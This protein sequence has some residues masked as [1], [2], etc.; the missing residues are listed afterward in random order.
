MF[1][2]RLS[3]S[4]LKGKRAA[5]RRRIGR[6]RQIAAQKE[7]SEGQRKNR[8]DAEAAAQTEQRLQ[9]AVSTLQQQL[10]GERKEFSKEKLQ[11]RG[12]MRLS[13]SKRNDVHQSTAG[14]ADEVL[15]LRKE[16]V[17]AKAAAGAREERLQSELQRA[18]S[19]SETRRRV[20]ADSAER[21]V[22]EL[23]EHTRAQEQ[24]I[25]A[26]Q[27]ECGRA[28][29]RLSLKERQLSDAGDMLDAWRFE[30]EDLQRLLRASELRCKQVEAELVRMQQTALHEMRQRQAAVRV[31]CLEHVHNCDLRAKLKLT[32]P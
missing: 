5:T 29:D 23:E 20:L 10:L 26:L 1:Q 25:A 15:A 18:G 24:Q 32:R 17:E 4:E 12:R 16:L 28:E 13:M 6:S 2:A 14:M 8:E 21:K 19:A 27:S 30:K 22:K 31:K 9:Q 7:L 11:L 3:D